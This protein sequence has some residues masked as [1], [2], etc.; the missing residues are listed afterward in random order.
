M[1]GELDVT[2]DDA[3]RAHD[4]G[5]ASELWGGLDM[6]VHAV[7]FAEREDLR[8]RFLT[9]SREN[10]A[11]GAGDQRLL[12]GG[13]GARGRAVDGSAR[14]R[15]DPDAQLPRRGARAAQLQRDGRGQGGSGSLRALSR[16]RPRAEKYPR[17]RDQRRA[18]AHA[19]VLGDPR[20]PLPWRTRSRSARRCAAR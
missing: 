7:A 11:Q 13:A 19:V 2:N 10:F 8:D 6:L 5:V 12:A 15:L 4:V 18:R 20:L 3:D 1:I 16:G 17:Q 14:R 9:V